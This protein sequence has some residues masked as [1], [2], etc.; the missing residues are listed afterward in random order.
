MPLAPVRHH[1]D[2]L[3]DGPGY[4]AE[5]VAGCLR[6]ADQATPI[7]RALLL[8]AARGLP[9]D[10]AE[11]SQLFLGVHILAC[12]RDEVSF[13]ILLRLLRRPHDAIEPLLGDALTETL[14]K[15][16]A[17]LF[18]GDTDL[19]LDTLADIG[20]DQLV[21]DALWRATAFL[22]FAGRIAT[23]VT[24]AF[25][26]RFDEE[27]MAPDRDMAWSAGW[28]RSRFS[29][30]RR[31]RRASRRCGP[32]GACPRKPSTASSS[33]RTL[34]PRSPRRTTRAASRP[35]ARGSSRMSRP[36]WRG[37]IGT[38]RRSPMSTRCAISAATIPARVEAARKP[39]SAASPPRDGC[40]VMVTA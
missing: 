39:R 16:V 3:A 25:V 40:R 36:L 35:S 18:D 15:V 17:S 1:I 6:Q 31:C 22:T 37:L 23:E 19:L 27:R 33:R 20:V 26:V 8:R 4:P 21:R 10:D 14:P 28:R 13:P 24:T 5:A 32:T 29:A 34:P 7:L 30:L 2:A 12:L 38:G 11:A 9:L